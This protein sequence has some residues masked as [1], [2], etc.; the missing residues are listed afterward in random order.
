MLVSSSL[1]YQKLE[2]RDYMWFTSVIPSVFSTHWL[3]NE[4][5]LHFIYAAYEFKKCKIKLTYETS[6][7]TSVFGSCGQ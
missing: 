7:H 1:D 5:L 6:I 4:Y 3:L 2:E